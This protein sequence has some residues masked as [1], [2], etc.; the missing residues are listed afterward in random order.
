MKKIIKL[1]SLPLLAIVLVACTNNGNNTPEET[2]VEETTVVES[3]SEETTVAEETTTAENQESQA[4]EEP[5]EDAVAFNFY[6]TGE[7]EPIAQFTVNDAA[8]MSVLEAME[9]NEE[10]DFTFNET[11]G[12]IDVIEGHTNDYE[13]GN[14]W[15]YLYNGQFAEYGVVSQTLEAGD[16]IDWYYGSID[17]IPINIIPAE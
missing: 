16:T 11:E 4:S 15:T 3:T 6:I 10:L 12:V 5:A 17:Q 7:E 8:G 9:S 2:T 1:I 14:T 13:M